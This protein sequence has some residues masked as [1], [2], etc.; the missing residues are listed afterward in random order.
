MPVGVNK[1][2]LLRH[3]II[4]AELNEIIKTKI[5]GLFFFF[6]LF[7]KFRFAGEKEL[8]IS[9]CEEMGTIKEK[10]NKTVKKTGS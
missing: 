7:V 3:K 4:Q 10:W 2:A 1:T 5:I 6:E 9:S 8:R